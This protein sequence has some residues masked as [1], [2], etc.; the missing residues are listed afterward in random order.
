MSVN[1]CLVKGL[2][3]ALVTRAN[4]AVGHCR[5]NREYLQ[6]HEIIEYSKHLRSSH[7]IEEA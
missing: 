3:K 4:T 1:V 2:A 6:Y 5:A 7:A